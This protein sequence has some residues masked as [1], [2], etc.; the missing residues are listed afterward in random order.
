VPAKRYWHRKIRLLFVSRRYFPGQ[1][2]NTIGRRRTLQS[3][4][5]F[6]MS[7]TRYF[8]RSDPPQKE[9]GPALLLVGL[10]PAQFKRSPWQQWLRL[11]SGREKV[12]IARP[13]RSSSASTAIL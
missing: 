5:R 13:S 8:R 7:V 9:F 10:P 11:T 2:C 1:S 6:M 12:R 4:S 3:S